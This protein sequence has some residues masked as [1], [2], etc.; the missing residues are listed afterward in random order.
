MA[1]LYRALLYGGAMNTVGSE[2][3]RKEISRILRDLSIDLA[4]EAFKGI[5]I[6]KSFAEVMN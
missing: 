3:E 4:G 2:L 5:G 6:L 1:E